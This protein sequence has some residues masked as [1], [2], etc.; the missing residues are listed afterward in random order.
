MATERTRSPGGATTLRTLNAFAVDVMGISSADD[1]FWYVAQNVAGRLGFVDCVIYTVDEARQELVQ[2]AALGDKNPYGRTIVNPL[3]IP[4]GHGITGRTAQ[5]RVAIVVDDLLGDVDYIPDTQPARSEICVPLLSDGRLL[6]VIDS[7]HPEVGAF[8]L[9][10]REV[11]TTVAAMT[12]AKLTL[13]AEAER[14]AQRYRDLVRSHA[15]LTQETENRKKLEAA[16][17]DAR[18]MEAIGRLTGGFA[19]EFNNLLTVIGGNM[20]L[21]REAVSSATAR[22][23]AAE[24][25]DAADRGAKLIRDMLAF[26]Q[27]THLDPRPT[28]V[29]VLVQETCAR[30]RHLVAGALELSLDEG[31]WPALVDATATEVALVNLMMNARDARPDGGVLRITTDNVE[32]AGGAD[33]DRA[34]DLLPGRYLRLSVSDEGP[35]IDARDLPRIFDPFFSTKS[36]SRSTGL[37]LSMIMGFARQSGGAVTARSVAGQGTTFELYLPA[38]AGAVPP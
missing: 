28:Q 22:A 4:F 11:L 19:H 25:E 23:F 38:D 1:L 30:N 12:S 27:R 14:S 3:R 32:H 15:Q 16:L 8:G 36:E 35:G 24:A 7:E 33:P 9:A 21:L 13:L 37:G 18:K 10:E 34:L 5:S 31:A 6:G 20:G 29:N 26:A 17:Y 2:A